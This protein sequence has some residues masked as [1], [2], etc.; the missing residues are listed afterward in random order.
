MLTG[1]D[2]FTY[3]QLS[4]ANECLRLRLRLRLCLAGAFYVPH[5]DNGLEWVHEDGGPGGSPVHRVR[6]RNSRAYTA[7]LYATDN[8]RSWEPA[9]GGALRLYLGSNGGE[10]RTHQRSCM[11]NI[12][13]DLVSHSLNAH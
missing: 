11:Q 4:W 6:R 2:N 3:Y 10:V 8:E 13:C 12:N 5:S 9:D 1:A 7:I